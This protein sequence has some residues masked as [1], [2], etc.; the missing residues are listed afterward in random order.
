MPM[1]QLRVVW[2]VEGYLIESGKYLYQNQQNK[3]PSSCAIFDNAWRYFNDTGDIV[4][5]LGKCPLRR[6]SEFEN[7]KGGAH[8]SSREEVDLKV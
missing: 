5:S 7:F 2:Y 6:V 4:L 3:P 8:T 1:S